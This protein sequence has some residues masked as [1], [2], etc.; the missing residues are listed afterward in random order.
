MSHK[1]LTSLLSIAKKG[2]GEFIEEDSESTK[3]QNEFNDLLQ[4]WERQTQLI[5]SSLKR[6]NSLIT[7]GRSSKS[8]MALGAFE[9]HLNLAMHSKKV[10]EVD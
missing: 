10:S 8:I 2:K 5:L 6:N 9:T 1:E 3:L 7:E 4:E